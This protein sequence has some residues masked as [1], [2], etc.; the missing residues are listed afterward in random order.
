MT[1][2]PA[3]ERGGLPKSKL[4]CSLHF[5]GRELQNV[6]NPVDQEARD[7]DLASRARLNNQDTGC[8]ARTVFPRQA[9]RKPQIVHRARRGPEG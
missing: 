7:L 2:Q 6:R 8:P 9:E 5:L 3:D 1:D 4:R